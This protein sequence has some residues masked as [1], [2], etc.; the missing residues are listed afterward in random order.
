MYLKIPSRISS[1]LS[2]ETLLETFSEN[3]PRIPYGA[4]LDDRGTLLSHWV[5]GI[6]YHYSPDTTHN[7]QVLT[8]KKG[9]S[10]FGR[11]IMLEPRGERTKISFMKM[12]NEDSLENSTVNF[13]LNFSI[14]FFPSCRNCCTSPLI[15]S[16][17]DSSKISTAISE[18]FQENPL[19]IFLGIPLQFFTFY[20]YMTFQILAKF[21]FKVLPDI[22]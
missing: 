13:L 10:S 15:K 6:K 11:E 14:I 17:T 20:P 7:T 19:E 4:N 12:K 22:H 9:I 5:S 16:F 18:H 8:H 2:S 3:L 21:H 1:E